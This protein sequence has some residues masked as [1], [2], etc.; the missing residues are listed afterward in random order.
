MHGL[1]PCHM[2]LVHGGPLVSGL[3]LDEIWT[4]YGRGMDEI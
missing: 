4:R 3:S 1:V 2:P